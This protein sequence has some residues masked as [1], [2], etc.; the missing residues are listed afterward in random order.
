MKMSRRQFVRRS[1]AA[2][3]DATL[4]P[5][6]MAETF[7][8]RNG[9]PLPWKQEP[10][11][12]EAAK[13]QFISHPLNPRGQLPRQSQHLAERLFRSAIPVSDPPCGGQAIVSR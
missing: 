10:S 2:A 1:S 9:S 11:L 6:L 7:D 3:G 12:R 5:S 13:T 4:F 8:S